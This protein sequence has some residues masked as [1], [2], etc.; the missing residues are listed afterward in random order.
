MI[1]ASILIVFLMSFVFDLCILRMKKKASNR[2]FRLVQI[3]FVLFN[4]MASIYIYWRIEDVCVRIN[5]LR[6]RKKDKQTDVVEIILQQ[7]LRKKRKPSARARACANARA[8]ERKDIRN[9]NSTVMLLFMLIAMHWNWINVART[10][11]DSITI[12][13]IS[14]PSFPFSSSYVS[15]CDVLEQI[16]WSV[17]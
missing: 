8:S 14:F 15:M 5:K 3:D 2:S 10:K 13:N 16:L 7:I 17:I 11:S 12:N 4:L 1:K 6:V 9:N